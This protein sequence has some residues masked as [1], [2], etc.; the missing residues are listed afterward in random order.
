[1]SWALS[2]YLIVNVDCFR[3]SLC[4]YGG[5]NQWLNSIA[6]RNN[7]TVAMLSV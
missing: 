4:C 3:L 1:M 2:S 6:E 7:G 5:R